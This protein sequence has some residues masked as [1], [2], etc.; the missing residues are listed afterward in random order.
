V[1]VNSAAANVSKSGG[2]DDIAGHLI[3][4]STGFLFTNDRE[5]VDAAAVVVEW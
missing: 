5:W 3:A 2:G 4:I 1:F